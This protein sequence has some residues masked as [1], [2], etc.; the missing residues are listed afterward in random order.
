M[1]PKK[2]VSIP[3]EEE[4]LW[5]KGRLKK[6]LL[7]KFGSNRPPWTILSRLVPNGTKHDYDQSN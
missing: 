6:Q 5:P 4:L 2:D 1:E 3:K 7:P